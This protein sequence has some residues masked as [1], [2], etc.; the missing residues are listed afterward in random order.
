MNNAET[1]RAVAAERVVRPLRERLKAVRGPWLGDGHTRMHVAELL[2]VLNERDAL[3][4]L[5]HHLRHCRE[6]GETDI[7][8]CVDGARIWEAAMHEAA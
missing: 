4:D 3:R 5:A 2:G 6:C 1:P 8:N 7:A